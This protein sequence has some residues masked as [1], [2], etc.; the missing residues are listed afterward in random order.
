MN[1]FWIAG[2]LFDRHAYSRAEFEPTVVFQNKRPDFIVL[3]FCP[4]CNFTDGQLPVFDPLKYAY[5]ERIIK[6]YGQFAA[7]FVHNKTL[8]KYKMT[9]MDNPEGQVTYLNGLFRR[10]GYLPA[11]TR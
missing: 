6:I 5:P 9:G 8:L 4:E 10:P 3:R 11:L 1:P 2:S 7:A